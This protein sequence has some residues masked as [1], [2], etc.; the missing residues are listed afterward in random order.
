M[1]DPPNRRPSPDQLLKRVEAEERYHR[2]G[3]LKVFLG[4]ASGVGKTFRMLDEGRRRKMRG[5]DVV[6]GYIQR[7][8]S[9]EVEELTRNLEVIPSPP[10]LGPPAIDVPTLLRRHPEVCLID[11]LAY[12]N[13]PGA[14]HEQR[15]QDV[16][17][18]LDGGI[19][20]IT[21]IN[22]QFVQ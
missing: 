2:R 7:A 15:W 12:K 3:K 17:E 5:Q 9:P 19:S 22:L 21:S 6:V 8:V 18:L 1:P 10:A 13:P 20:V 11:G 4:Y 14:A 16:E